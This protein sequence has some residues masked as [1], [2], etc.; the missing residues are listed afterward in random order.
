MPLR[1]PIV[2]HS[3]VYSQAVELLNSM[4]SAPSCN[5]MAVSN[6]LASCQSLEGHSAMVEPALD[7]I[8]STYAASLA[9]CEIEGAGSLVP[10]H[11]DIAELSNS[12]QVVR[13]YVRRSGGQLKQ[14][15]QSLE[16]RPQWW[17]SYSNG[18]Q[19]A[20]LLCQAARVEIEKG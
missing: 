3:E 15:L 2:G 5:R 9:I 16:S 18:K 8:R 12:D 10:P 6:L 17:T 20:V 1:L 14:C 11:C 4:H 13:G 19:N 7:D